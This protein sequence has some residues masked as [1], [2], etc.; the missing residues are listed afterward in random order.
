MKG[1]GRGGAYQRLY[2]PETVKTI[3]GE[4]TK[5]EYFTPEKGMGQGVHIQ[6]K[7][8]DET[9]PVHLGP[10]WFLDE[11]E[12]LIEKG[13]QIKVKGSLI[14]FKEKPALIAAEVE[15]GEDILRLRDNEGFPQWAGW[16]GRRR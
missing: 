14:T 9:L 1:W 15:K 3:S 4:V 8:E 5:V 12:I 6:V 16:R 13:D 11:Q 7:T 2:D 10:R